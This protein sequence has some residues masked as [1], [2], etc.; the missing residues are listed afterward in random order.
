MEC[1]NCKWY[2]QW[3]GVCCNPDCD[4]CLEFTD[5]NFS[6]GVWEEKQ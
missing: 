2:E 3:T 5:E 6:C 4:V 1:S